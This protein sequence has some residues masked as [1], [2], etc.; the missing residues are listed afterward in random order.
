MQS[1]FK[2]NYSKHGQTIAALQDLDDV[3]RPLPSNNRERLRA[4]RQAELMQR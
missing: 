1:M 3:I 2:E 4:N